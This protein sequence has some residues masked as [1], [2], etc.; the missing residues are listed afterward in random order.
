MSNPTDY[1]ALS[2]GENQF[3]RHAQRWGSDGYFITKVQSKWIWEGAFGVSGSPIVY[4]TKKAAI[5]A[6][7][8]YIDSL[9]DRIHANP[10]RLAA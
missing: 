6:V 1:Q 8:A 9:L 7:D 10:A 3:L 4:K 2:E 5:A